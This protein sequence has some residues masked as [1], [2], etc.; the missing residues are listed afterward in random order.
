MSNVIE[1]PYANPVNGEL[2]RLIGR[3]NYE[4]LMEMWTAILNDEFDDWFDYY[5]QFDGYVEHCTELSDFARD[6]SN[7]MSAVNLH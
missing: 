2:F 4:M 3:D 5:V 7:E 6:L 1:L